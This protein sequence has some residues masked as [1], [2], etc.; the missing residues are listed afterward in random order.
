MS[1]DGGRHV[2]QTR[3]I[4][5]PVGSGLPLGFFAFGIGMLLLGCLGLSWIPV[6]EQTD[7]GMLL[8]SFVFPLQLLATVFAFLARDTLE[9]RRWG[10]SPGRRLPSA[11]LC[12]PLRRARPRRPSLSTCP[13]SGPRRCCSPYSAIPAK[14]FFSVLLGIAA[15]RMALSGSYELGASHDLYTA[16]G[17]CAVAPAALAM[18]G[19]TALGLE[20]AKHREVL[21]LFR[22]G[23]AKEAF[24]GVEAQLERLESEPGVRQQL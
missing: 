24:E 8:M 2:Q 16:S 15:V 17:A 21:P 10:C 14:P 6:S 23:G 22:R 4:L 7:V 20:D 12:M 3:V 13:P 1:T 19:A 11:G 18:Y 9:P 5:R